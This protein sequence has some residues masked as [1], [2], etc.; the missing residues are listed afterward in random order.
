MKNIYLLLIFS[1]LFTLNAKAQVTIGSLDTPTE[2]AI[3]ELK[4]ETLGFLPTRVMLVK[5]SL[6]DPIPSHIEG[7]V[8]YNMTENVSDTLRVGLYYNTGSRWVRLHTAPSFIENWFYMPSIVFDTSEPWNVEHSINLYDEF[9]KQL[10]SNVGIIASS[11]ASTKV[12]S[13]IPKAKDLYYYVT[14]YDSDVFEILSISGEGEM[15]YKIKAQATDAT[16][17]N[18]VFVKK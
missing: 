16:Y 11:G 4:S 9:K 1:T 17:M 5:L 14:A 7:M 3:L 12:L 6:P 2:G 18:I 15:K 13:T 8:V 10:N